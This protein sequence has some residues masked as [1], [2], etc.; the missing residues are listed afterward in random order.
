MIN[1]KDFSKLRKEIE[2]SE[3]QRDNL[4]NK[5]REVIKISKKLIYAVHRNESKKAEVERKKLETAF[6][7]IKKL[8]R[9]GPYKIAAQEYV[10]AIAY[11]HYYK[12]GKLIGL[13]S[14]NVEP[15]HYL[16]GIGD[17]TGELGRRAVN[18]VIN[19]D[20]KEFHRIKELVVSLYQEMLLFDFRNND[21]RRKVD[22]MKYEVKKLEDISLQLKLKQR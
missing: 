2:K 9:N 21:L 12:N 1:K 15:E 5:S 11:W 19:E 4:I 13:S 17:L 18:S 3:I 7:D 14:L 22:G 16:L 20:Y 8:G 6:Q 10:E